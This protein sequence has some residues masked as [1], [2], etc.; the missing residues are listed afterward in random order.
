MEIGFALPVT[1]S[2]ATAENCIDIAESAERL[3]Y[4]SLWSFQRL[5]SPVTSEGVQWLPPAYHSV[6]D[7]FSVLAFAAARTSRVRLGVAV[8]NA[9]FYPV[10]LLAKIAATIDRLSHGRLDLGLGL[11]WMPEEFRAT[12]STMEK[13]GAQLV[14]TITALQ[15]IWAGGVVAFEGSSVS[16]PDSVVEPLPVQSPRPPLILG[17]SAPA[18]LQRAG[19]IADGWVSASTADLQTLGDPIQIVRRAAQDAGRDPDR[20]RFI[21][22]GVVKVRTGD[23]SPLTGSIEQI[24][25]DLQR[26]AEQGM[27]ETFI[28]LNFDPEIGAV[29]ADPRR[30]M[31]RAHELLEALAP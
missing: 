11:G 20:L 4:S 9:P 25:D 28:D 12:G 26:I 7:P 6:L 8:I 19:R 22:R 18:A 24:R 1:G 29:G 23:R 10:L 27:T 3:G 30:S 5:L 21:C 13:R 15:S 2:W 16:I 31:E 14:E 17:G